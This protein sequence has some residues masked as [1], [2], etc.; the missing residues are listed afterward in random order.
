M[1]G[2]VPVTSQQQYTISSTVTHYINNLQSTFLASMLY[3]DSLYLSI[4]YLS[5]YLE[6]PRDYSRP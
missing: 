1:S 4:G 6:D 5:I 3:F 2:C